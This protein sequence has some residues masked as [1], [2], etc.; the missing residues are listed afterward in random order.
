[1]REHRVGLEHHVDRAAV[2][3]H[4]RHIHPVDQDAA[5]AGYF[6]PGQHPQQGGLAAAGRSEQREK[7]AHFDI[8][9]DIVDRDK[10][11]KALGDIF[12]PDEHQTLSLLAISVPCNFI[13]ISVKAMVIAIST[14][15]AALTSGVTE[16]RTIE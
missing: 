2:G 8:E 13:P 11:A 15:E 5:F 16:N 3:R 1:M 12:K 7:F 4:A 6:Q 9:A 14:V 10:A